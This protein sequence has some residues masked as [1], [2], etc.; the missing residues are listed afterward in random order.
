MAAFGGGKMFF[1]M[2]EGTEESW[3]VAK[4]GCDVCR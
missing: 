4:C 2:M 3:W 1:E